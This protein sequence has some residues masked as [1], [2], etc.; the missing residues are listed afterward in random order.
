MSQRI[1]NRYGITSESYIQIRNYSE[2]QVGGKQR[3]KQAEELMYKRGFR[4]DLWPPGE[5]TVFPQNKATEGTEDHRTTE[6]RA[7]GIWANCTH[8]LYCFLSPCSIG[9]CVLDII[10]WATIQL[11]GNSPPEKVCGFLFSYFVAELKKKKKKPDCQE[12]LAHRLPGFKWPQPQICSFQ[13]PQPSLSVSQSWACSFLGQE[14]LSVFIPASWL[15][16]LRCVSSQ[17]ISLGKCSHHPTEQTSC[18]C[19]CFQR[20]TFL[21]TMEYLSLF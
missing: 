17:V 18:L 21:F 11:W 10:P 8:F 4:I 12:I 3:R 13:L 7:R 19:M 20:T 15:T 2:A 1:I 5:Q 6:L 16:W 14:P 9:I